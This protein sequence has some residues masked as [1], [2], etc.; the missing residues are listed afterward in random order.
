MKLHENVDKKVSRSID[1][2][3][4]DEKLESFGDLNL[5]YQF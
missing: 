1:W 2:E 3:R 5:Q 4:L